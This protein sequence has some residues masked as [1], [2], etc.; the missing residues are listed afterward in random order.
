MG[1]LGR[2]GLLQT[3]FLGYWQGK[4]MYS[5]MGC[6]KSCRHG[7]ENNFAQ[8]D[9]EFLRYVVTNEID[10]RTWKMSRQSKSGSGTWLEKMLKSMLGLANYYHRSF[11][12]FLRLLGPCVTGLG[13]GY[14]KNGKNLATKALSNSIASYFCHMCSN[15]QSFTNGLR[16]IRTWVTLPLVG[17]WYEMEFHCIWEQ[18]TITPSTHRAYKSR[19]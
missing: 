6:W 8:Q 14:S 5:P 13:K 19:G 1:R 18:K 15:F 16:C 4:R 3:T 12:I 2:M 17:C 9:I 7:V 11:A 10:R